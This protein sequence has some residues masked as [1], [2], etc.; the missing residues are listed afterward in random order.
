M[1]FYDSWDCFMILVFCFFVFFTL[2]TE[3]NEDNLQWVKAKWLF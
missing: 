1:L 3:N 2:V